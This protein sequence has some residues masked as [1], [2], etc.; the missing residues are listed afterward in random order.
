MQQP[1]IFYRELSLTICLA[2]ADDYVI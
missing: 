1:L 2:Y